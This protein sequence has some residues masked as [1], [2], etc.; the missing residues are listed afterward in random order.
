M[1]LT[2]TPLHTDIALHGCT[3]LPLQVKERW[4]SARVLGTREHQGKP[5][6]KVSLDGFDD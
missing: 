5:Q 2:V 3:V 6:F 4:V 1:G